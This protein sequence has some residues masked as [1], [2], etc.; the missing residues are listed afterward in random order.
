MW[1]LFF[2][3]I[4]VIITLSYELLIDR[5]ISSL[6]LLISNGLFWLGP[7]G[8]AIVIACGLREAYVVI[9]GNK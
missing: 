4:A 8:L 6:A 2:G 7:I 9:K 3:I 5:R 1:W